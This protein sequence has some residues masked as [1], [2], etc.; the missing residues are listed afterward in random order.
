MRG[1]TPKSMAK[2]RLP[3]ETAEKVAAITSRM[4][5]YPRKLLS[6]KLELSN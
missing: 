4:T 2:S 1:Q 6:P 3:D 5:S